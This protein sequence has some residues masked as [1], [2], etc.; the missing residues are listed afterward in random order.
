MRRFVIIMLLAALAVAGV[1]SFFAATSPD[2]LERVAENLG[3]SQ[4]AQEPSVSVL[5]DYSVPG[6]TGFLSNG[7]AGMIGVA[8]VF[9]L[10]WLLGKAAL[11]GKR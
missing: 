3:F 10:A 8:A 2:G 5:P 1:V 7:I 4:A 6:L 11:R 9:G